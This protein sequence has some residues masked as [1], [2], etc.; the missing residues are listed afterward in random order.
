MNTSFCRQ[1]DLVVTRLL[2][3][4]GHDDKII[5]WWKQINPPKLQRKSLSSGHRIVCFGWGTSNNLTTTTSLQIYGNVI[6]DLMAT[7]SSLLCKGLV[8]N[9]WGYEILLSGGH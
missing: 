1:T 7:I 9:E 2:C 4:E 5:T 3:I 6:R 8:E